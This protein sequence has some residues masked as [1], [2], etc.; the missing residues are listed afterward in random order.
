MATAD[1]DGLVLT[2][3]QVAALCR[4]LARKRNNTFWMVV[5]LWDERDRLLAQAEGLRRNAATGSQN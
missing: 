1:D 3:E 2:T 5:G 4:E